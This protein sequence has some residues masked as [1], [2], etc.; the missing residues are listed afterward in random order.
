MAPISPEPISCLLLDKRGNTTL[1]EL[2]P[3][4]ILF[5]NFRSGTTILQKAISTHPDVVAWSEPVSLS[6]YRAAEHA[7]AQNGL[8]GWEIH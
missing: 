1:G 5:G 4:L 8:N 2:K 6:K 7:L 3:T